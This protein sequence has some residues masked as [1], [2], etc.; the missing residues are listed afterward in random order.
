VLTNARGAEALPAEARQAVAIAGSDTEIARAA[1]ALLARPEE[2]A[3]M[4]REGR[5]YALRH[6]DW[7]HH[8]Q[9]FHAELRRLRGAGIL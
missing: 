3:R 8:R 4:R 1:R 9:A 6:F 2:L 5:A 7:S